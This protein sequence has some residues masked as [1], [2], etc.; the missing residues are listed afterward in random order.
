M[1]EAKTA[2]RLW[3]HRQTCRKLEQPRRG[4]RFWTVQSLKGA[5][6]ECGSAA[7][8]HSQ[9]EELSECPHLLNACPW[10]QLSIISGDKR[11]QK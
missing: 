3:I 11:T 5:S 6:A 8:R 10:G 7:N 9:R 1:G 4:R 2:Q